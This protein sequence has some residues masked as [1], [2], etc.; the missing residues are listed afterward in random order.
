MKKSKKVKKIIRKILRILNSIVLPIFFSC[1]GIIIF[2]TSYYVLTY[3]NCS[4]VDQMIYTMTTVE[5]VSMQP[6]VDGITYVLLRLFLI[7]FVIVF[8]ILLYKLFISKKITISIN[9]LYLKINNKTI[10]I[11]PF[12]NLILSLILLFSS[13]FYAFYKF[14]VDEYLDANFNKGEIFEDEYVDPRGIKLT[15]PDK[16]RNL[17]Y[18]YVESLETSALSKEHGG[19]EKESYIPKLEKLALENL[20]FSSNDTV[21]GGY[22]SYGGTWTI[23]GMISQSAG[24]PLKVKSGMQNEYKSENFLSGAYSLGDVL[25]NN[26][27]KNYF[28][29]GED[30]TFAGANL[31]YKKHG[32][33]EIY[34]YDWAKKEKLIPE[35]YYEMW[36]FEDKKLFEYSKKKLLEI[37]KNDE[38]FNFVMETMDTHFPDGYVDKSCSNK[39][40][41]K[42][43]NAYYCSDSMILEF[44]KWV[45]GQDFYDNTTI[46]ISGDHLTMKNGFFITTDKDYQRSVYNVIINSA[47][48]TKYDKNRQFTTLDMYPT[49]LAS[50]GVKIQ[51]EKLGLGTN[52][53][54]GNLTLTEKYGF[55][56]LNEELKKYSDYY[57]N[58]ILKSDKLTMAEEKK[59]DESE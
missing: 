30:S 36:G 10:K 37:S 49:T 16:K 19:I 43:A 53:Y 1:L 24:L 38:P 29:L 55:E 56:K 23:A 28:I 27:Y 51:G 39:F 57:N 4:S 47:I 26:G 32:N 17:I 25:H 58:E 46:I 22:A 54:S 35:D 13:L 45:Q 50:L 6:L 33:Y 44:V 7:V 40:E 31:Y 12:H 52:L 41:A 14:D 34:D 3:I 48:D 9:K 2:I 5:G 20:N 15:F 18:I 42:Y 8:L 21:G 11:F 59:E